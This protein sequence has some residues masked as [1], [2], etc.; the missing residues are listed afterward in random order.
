MLISQ[1]DPGWDLS[2]GTRAP[3]RDPKTV[4][5]TDKYSGAQ[6][7]FHSWLTALRNLVI[8]YGKPV[9]YVNGDS[10]YM[11]IDKPLLDVN[12]KRIESFTRVET[13]GDNQTP[14]GNTNDVQWLKVLV[15]PRSRD[16]FAFQ[17]HVVPQNYSVTSG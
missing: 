2:D 5:E 6:D 15:D 12:G 16:V 14:A 8:E 9:A 7:G 13:F 10:H 17:P 4:E 11:R 1:G 3:V